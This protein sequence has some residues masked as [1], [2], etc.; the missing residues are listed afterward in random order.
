MCR[1]CLWPSKLVNIIFYC[2]SQKLLLVELTCAYDD[3]AGIAKGELPWWETLLLGF[4]AGAYVAVGGT[5][6]VMMTGGFTGP[7]SI[8]ASN[9]E[10]Y[11]ACFDA[12]ACFNLLIGRVMRHGIRSFAQKYPVPDTQNL[13]LCL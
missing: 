9:R 7:G 2:S 8:A 13:L 5:F 1:R 10:C 11:L 4:M 6:A 12:C 3:P